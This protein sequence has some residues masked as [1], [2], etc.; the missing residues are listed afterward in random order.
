MKQWSRVHRVKGWGGWMLQS[1]CLHHQILALHLL[2]TEPPI[3]VSLSVKI[4]KI[5]T[6]YICYE[7]FCCGGE[8]HFPLPQLPSSPYLRLH[9]YGNSANV[10]E[11]ETYMQES[12]RDRKATRAWRTSWARHEVRCLGG[13]RGSLQDDKKSRHLVN[14]CLPCHIGGSKRLSLIVSYYE[15]GP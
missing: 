10:K 14:K 4:I 6:A 15:Q 1:Y 5:P 12:F 8:T 11:S 13:F 7:I 3:L 2:N 9:V